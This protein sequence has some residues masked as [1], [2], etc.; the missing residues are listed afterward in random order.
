MPKANRST[1][2]ILIL[3]VSLFGGYFVFAWTEPTA[4]PP[5]GNVSTPLNVSSTAQEKSGNL[6]FTAFYDYNNNSYFVD[7]SGPVSALLAGN[8]G[9]GTTST[10]NTK[11]AITTLNTGTGTLAFNY[12]GIDTGKITYN[13]QADTMT[14]YT[15]GDNPR[16]TI[17]R[18]GVVGVGT[19]AGNSR[20]TII[21]KN[22]GAGTLGFS[23]GGSDI[24]YISY[25]QYTGKMMF[26]VEL[27]KEMEIRT[28]GIYA[29]NAFNA[30]AWD[31]AEH[32]ETGGNLEPGDVVEIAPDNPDKTRLSSEAYSSLLLGVISTK[33]GFVLGVPLNES[34][35]S[36]TTQPVALAGRVPTKVNTENGPIQPGDYLTSSSLPGQAMKAT[37]PGLILGRA[38]ESFDGS[39]GQTGKITVLINVSWYGGSDN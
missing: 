4:S 39:S 21:S 22:T 32:F 37:K 1:L 28:A 10:S 36:G 24:G 20:L 23:Y 19:T 25:D 3:T 30:N 9:I 13:Q 8:V 6:T 15:N 17:D 27:A 31:L 33:P 11:L 35:Q 2:I 26:Y 38:L 12:G 18:D 14:F 7:P 5:G 29:D 34:E 16:M